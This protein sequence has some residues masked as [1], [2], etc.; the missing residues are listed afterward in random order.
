MTA[1]RA[2]AATSIRAIV[3]PMPPVAPVRITTRSSSSPAA[4]RSASCSSPISSCIRSLP[5]LPSRRS[6]P[7]AQTFRY[8][9][10][11]YGCAAAT[12]STRSR[13]SPGAVGSDRW[14][15]AASISGLPGHELGGPRIVERIEML[16]DQEVRD[17]RGELQAE[18]RRDRAA[19]L[20]GRDPRAGRAGE[21]GDA[22]ASRRSR[23]ATSARAARSRRRPPWRA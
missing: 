13:P 18:R 1:T 10:S 2:P 14:P 9:F 3:V 6:Q 4:A 19:A 22:P 11:S 8:A 5:S 21:V 15:V 20:M 17:A 12:S 23:R 7:S 16:L